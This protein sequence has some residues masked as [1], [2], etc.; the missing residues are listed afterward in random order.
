[1]STIHLLMPDDTSPQLHSMA[2]A[3]V[4]GNETVIIRDKKE[5]PDLRNKRILFASE[6]SSAGFNLGMLEMLSALSDRGPESLKGSVGAVIVRSSSE[7]NTKSAA[8]NIIFI[9]NMLGCRFM[10][11]PLVE[12]AGNFK[13]FRTWQKQ[14][15][16]P[17]PDI[18]AQMCKKLG[19]RLSS[20]Q[21]S[22]I[23]SPNIAALHSSSRST[24]NTLELWHMVSGCLSSCTVSELQ[25]ENGEVLDCIGCPYTTCIHFSN[26]NSC[27]YGGAMVKN[28]QPA[29]EKADA[30]IFICPNYNDSISAN[31]TAVINRLTA[32]YRKISFYNKSLF[33]VIVSG[34]SGGDSVARQLLGALNINKGFALPPYFCIMAT[35]NDPHQIKNVESI[36]EKAAAFAYNMMSEIKA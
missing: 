34:N 33:A 16:I 10:G 7:I 6:L 29:I 31:L 1:M 3:A 30:L 19:Q 27:F 12:D 23:Q 5:L 28:I 20:Y 21:P 17:L 4:S 14:L 36:R 35:A 8:Q 2:D 13:N 32:L 26:Q 18:C 22:V 9:A 24:S 11:H 25:V 15:N